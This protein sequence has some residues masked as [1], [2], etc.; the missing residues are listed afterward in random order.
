MFADAPVVIGAGAGCLGDAA[1]G[2]RCADLIGLVVRA[3]ALCAQFRPLPDSPEDGTVA[4]IIF[5]ALEA[6][7]D[8]KIAYVRLGRL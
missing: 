7:L 6:R 8:G 3:L 2:D 4:V 5:A 1:F